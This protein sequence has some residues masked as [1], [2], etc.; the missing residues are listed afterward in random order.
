MEVFPEK[1]EVFL[2]NSSAFF[3]KMA[4]FFLK[5]EV[6]SEKP[7]IDL[8]SYHSSLMHHASHCSRS[9]LHVNKKAF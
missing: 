5:T 4:V 3:W 8:S 9:R 1:M 7:E 6:I 2:K